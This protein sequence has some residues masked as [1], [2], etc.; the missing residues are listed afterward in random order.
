[1]RPRIITSRL[2]F[3]QQDIS[4]KIWK[5]LKI[6]LTR[7]VFYTIEQTNQYKDVLKTRTSKKV[8]VLFFIPQQPWMK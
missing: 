8:D 3:V 7:I 4:E 6:F 5:S 1:M 2:I